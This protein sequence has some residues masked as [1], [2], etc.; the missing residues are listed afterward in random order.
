MVTSPKGRVW[1]YSFGSV[2]ALVETV[3]AIEVT[4]VAD[5]DG[6]GF[7]IYTF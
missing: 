5:K 3:N 7:G 1:L 6:V 4:E 2:D